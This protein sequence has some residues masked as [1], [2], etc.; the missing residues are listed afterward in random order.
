MAASP[1]SCT[2]SFSGP[3]SQPVYATPGAAGADVKAHI[4]DPILIDPMTHAAI[5][6]GLFPE[7]PPGYQIEVRPRSG[8][9]LHHAVTVLN[10]PGTIVS[11]FRGEIKVI[12]INHGPHPFCVRNEDRIAQLVV[13]PVVR[14]T[15]QRK[16]VLSVTER[17]EDG[18][19]S[20]GV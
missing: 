15:F 18:F 14:A 2:V 8:M 12:L 9:A 16:E 13:T 3:G 6:T 17:G 19:G 11:D 1:E 4:G 20:T 10:A 7:I 5:G